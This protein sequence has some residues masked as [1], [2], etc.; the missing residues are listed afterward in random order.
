MWI[1]RREKT[2][3]AHHQTLRGFIIKN[4]LLEL[5]LSK[6]LSARDK[7]NSTGIQNQ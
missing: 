1:A 3:V 6:K 7:K 5:L 4:G 2:A